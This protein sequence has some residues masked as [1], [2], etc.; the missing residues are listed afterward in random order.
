MIDYASLAQEIL[1]TPRR[2]PDWVREQI[3][4]TDVWDEELEQLNL[5]EKAKAS[6][7]LGEKIT[8]LATVLE[9]RVPRE[10]W[11]RETTPLLNLVFDC[12][13]ALFAEGGYR[14][15]MCPHCGAPTGLHIS[16]WLEER[17]R[18]QCRKCQ[19]VI[20]GLLP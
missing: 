5:A 8:A 14:E 17:E 19:H 4:L 11:W 3:A 15:L 20:E 7:E 2:P 18:F 9:L 6:P 13:E 12:Q 16:D 1:E 10:A